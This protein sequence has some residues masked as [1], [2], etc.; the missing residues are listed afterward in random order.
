MY[1]QQFTPDELYKFVRQVERKRLHMDSNAVKEALNGEV[2][3][4]IRTDS[5]TFRIRQSGDLYLN[6]HPSGSIEAVGQDALMR[7]LADN[8]RRVSHVKQ[9][10]RNRIIRQ[11]IRLLQDEGSHYIL[12]LDIKSF[13]ESIDHD[14][15]LNQLTDE[16][17][18][19]GQSIR[20]MKEKI[21]K[22]TG[23][24]LPRGLGISSALAETY[25]KRFDYE[26]QHA[27][28]VYYF[29]RFVD[30]IIVFCASQQFLE[31]VKEHIGEWIKDKGLE[32]NR[33][34]SRSWGI[35]VEKNPKRCSQILGSGA[36]TYLGYDFSVDH[37]KLRISISAKKV[38]KI[39]TRIVRSFMSY[40][41]KPNFKLLEK[42]IKFLTGNFVLKDKTL[43][44]AVHV[45]IY[46]TYCHITQPS[47]EL[48]ELDRFYQNILHAS[49]TNVIGQAILNL[50]TQERS[51]LQRH[52]FACGFEKKI[53]HSFSPQEIKAMKSI[54]R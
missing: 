33:R 31:A 26:V 21:F 32:I 15:L 48:V 6:G 27:E 4:T 38:R 11:M 34:K 7:K 9:G 18:L 46:Y 49:K 8:V 45:G 3:E 44:R 22:Q 39:K 19:S 24:G 53:H 40:V 2:S 37:D 41:K 13:Y 16:G 30:D 42:R 14:R 1:T 23:N 5:Y 51:R 25:M 50:S 20:L 29:A 36:L 17:R 12:R 28:G 10:D 52:S 47:P 43:L 54:W 35:R